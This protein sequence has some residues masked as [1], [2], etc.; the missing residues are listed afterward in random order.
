MLYEVIEDN[1]IT[2]QSGESKLLYFI[3][4]DLSFWIIIEV[5]QIVFNVTVYFIDFDII[6]G[7]T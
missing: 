7:C 2:K 6:I 3:Q 1:L 5:A 4:K